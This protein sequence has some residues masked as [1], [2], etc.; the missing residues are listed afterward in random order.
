MQTE[1]YSNGRKSWVYVEKKS[2][3]LTGGYWVEWMD[4]QQLH[5][6]TPNRLK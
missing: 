1:A 4:Y 2:P 6:V 5:F 3:T